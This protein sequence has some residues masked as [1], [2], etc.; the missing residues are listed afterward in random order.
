M[1]KSMSPV[2]NTS[3]WVAACRA[4]ETESDEPLF[5]D[6]FARSLAGD[7]G[8][9]FHERASSIGTLPY[10]TIRTK[11]FDDEL[12]KFVREGH[13]R[14]V[15]LLAAGMDTR[16]FRF[17]WP[18]DLR[19][20]EVDRQEI[21]DHK[22][23]VLAGMNAK[24]SCERTTV[25]ADLGRDWI[26]ALSDAGFDATQPSVFLVE[27]LL[28]YLPEEMVDRLIIQIASV[29]PEGSVLLTDIPGADLLTSPFMAEHLKTLEQA[30]CPLIF[31]V[32]DPEAFC[33]R[34]GWSAKVVVPGEEK[35]NY[36][37]WTFPVVPRSVPGVP[38]SYL[39]TASRAA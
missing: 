21:F 14:Q 35:A 5:V 27:G 19:W 10:L 26:T 36:G 31:G 18:A 33:E 23:S 39:V 9:E 2:G 24:A 22:E 11:Y 6:P 13:I 4:I 12:Q 29:T 32:S 3:L 20:F 28:V 37:R 1:D 25:V 30:G 34:L 16:A 15:V 17:N 8:S 38:R 7:A